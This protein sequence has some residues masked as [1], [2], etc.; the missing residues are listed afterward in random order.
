MR[1]I[2]HMRGQTSPPLSS[3]PVASKQQVSPGLP[4]PTG[5][6]VDPSLSSHSSLP[7]ASE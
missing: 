5:D 2:K 6:P 3:L 1:E 4:L 7:A